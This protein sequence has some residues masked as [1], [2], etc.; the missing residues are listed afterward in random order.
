MQV[1]L[2]EP[3]DEI[4]DDGEVEHVLDVIRGGGLTLLKANI[5]YGLIGHTERSIRRMYEVKGR[6]LTNPCITIGNL[7]VLRDLVIPLDPRLLDWIAEVSEMTT[8]AVIN[9]LNPDSRLFN[10]LTPHVRRQCS[11]N[12]TV[13]TFIRTGAFVDKLVEKGL[14]EDLLLVGSSG[15]ISSTGNRYTFADVQPPVLEGVD[16]WHEKGDAKYRNDQKLATSIVNLT[17]FTF[18]RKGVNHEYIEQS[19]ADFRSRTGI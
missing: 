2:G 10:R 13:A 9:R 6:P 3:D 19:L 14:A 11:E 12:G 1:A 8:L 4:I 7:E 5:G 16:F 18:R 15:N 17:N